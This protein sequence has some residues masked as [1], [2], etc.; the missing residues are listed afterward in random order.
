[1]K[2]QKGLDTAE[3]SSAS[4]VQTLQQE[5]RGFWK[6]HKPKRKDILLLIA[7]DST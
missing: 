5:M 4:H 1:M 3:E 7:K 6:T 2:D